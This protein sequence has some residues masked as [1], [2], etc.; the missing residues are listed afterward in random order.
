MLRT[1]LKT[2]SNNK[3][4]HIIVEYIGRAF[5]AQIDVRFL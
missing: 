3:E 2:Y 5:L 4:R 1:C